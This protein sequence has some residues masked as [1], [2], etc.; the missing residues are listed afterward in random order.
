MGGNLGSPLGMNS[1]KNGKRTSGVEAILS[2]N[3]TIKRYRG[4]GQFLEGNMNLRKDHSSDRRYTADSLYA[5][6]RDRCWAL[7][8]VSNYRREILE[9][10]QNHFVFLCKSRIS[11]SLVLISLL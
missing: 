5:V 11:L 10:A 3:V 8:R 7:D 2:K 6:G 1:G 4:I 9:R